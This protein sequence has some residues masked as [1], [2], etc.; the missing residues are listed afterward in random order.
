M[1]EYY[2]EFKDKEFVAAHL[3]QLA[4]II[5]WHI[6]GTRFNIHL[7]QEGFLSAGE[8]KAQL[9]WMDARVGEYVVTP[10]HGC[11]VEIQ[12]LWYNAVK[13]YQFFAAEVNRTDDNGTADACEQLYSQM[14]KNFPIHFINDDGYLNDVVLPDLKV[15]D[16]LRPNQIYVLSLPFSLLNKAQEK[17][18]FAT[19]KKQLFTPYGLRTLNSDHPDF[20][21]LYGGDQW[22][23]DTAYHQGTVWPFLLGDYFLAMKKLEGNSTAYRKHLKETVEV[24]KKHFY[25]ADCIHGISEIFDGKTPCEGRGTT[26]QAWSIAALLMVLL[27][28]NDFNKPKSTKHKS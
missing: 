20:K 7:T 18:V 19:V 12:A 28:R 16:S 10:R 5:D 27:P 21:P 14:E 23:R 15:D 17:K 13:I 11:P 4:D 8:D 9:T 3:D 25:E 26:H 2:Q 6:K 24:L 1:Y 22:H